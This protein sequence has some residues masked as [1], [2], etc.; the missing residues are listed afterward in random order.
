MKKKALITGITGQDGSYLAE[1]LH[2]L[3]Y[4]VHGLVRRV[5]LE[6][7]EQRLSRLKTVLDKITIHAASLES[8][9]SIFHVFSREQF[10]ECYHLAA[11]SF[12]AESF[13]D[14]FSTMSTNINGTHYM[15]A[16]LRELQPKCK[17][18][19][20]GSSEMF[21]KV[22]ETPQTETTP[23]HPRSPYGISKCAGFQLAVNYREAYEMFCCNGILF[24][25]ESPRRGLEFVTRKITNGVAR[26]KLGMASELRL[27]NLDAKRDWGHARDYVSAMHLMLQQPSPDDYVIATGQTHSV[28]ELCQLAFSEAGLDYQDYVKI[29]QSVYRPAE[30]DLLIGDASKAR[31]ILHWEPSVDFVGLIKEMVHA[32]LAALSSTPKPAPVLAPA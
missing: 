21:G 28:K 13:A 4:E 10:D 1:H 14:G 25:H 24:N 9:P 19:F 32:D 8:Y 26:I 20:A 29:D 3:G 18:Y 6:Q 17:F 7:P 15:L 2:G 22:R 27:G 30:V 23:F 31:L 11:Q 12:V 16:A 5:A